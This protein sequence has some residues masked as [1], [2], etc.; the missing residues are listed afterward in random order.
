MNV[1]VLVGMHKQVRLTCLNFIA[2]VQ[3]EKKRRAAAD[4][5]LVAFVV[6][7]YSLERNKIERERLVELNR[8][9]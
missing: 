2:H 5:Y 8:L 9:Y 4:L 6:C 7:I 1:L 3:R